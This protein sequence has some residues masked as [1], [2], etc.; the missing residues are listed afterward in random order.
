MDASAAVVATRVGSDRTLPTIGNAGKQV[1]VWDL[2]IESGIGYNGDGQ[3]RY[4]RVCALWQGPYTLASRG[5]AFARR[6]EAKAR[7]V[8]AAYLAESK[9]LGS[10]WQHL[11]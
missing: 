10:K 1:A 4:S 2:D 3:A 6:L 5:T 9:H 11:L 7:L 8:S